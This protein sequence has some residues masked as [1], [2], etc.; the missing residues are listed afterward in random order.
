MPSDLILAH[1]GAGFA[2]DG[3]PI[4]FNIP[5]GWLMMY[6]RGFWKSIAFGLRILFSDALSI[7]FASFFSQGD[8]VFRDNPNIYTAFLF[9]FLEPKKILPFR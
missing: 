4:S 9:F 6:K 7:P 2:P 8:I 3:V 5:L 1:T